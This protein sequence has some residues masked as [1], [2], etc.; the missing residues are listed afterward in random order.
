M[1]SDADL[2]AD[3]LDALERAGCQFF[4]CGGPTLEP[5]GMVTCYRCVEVARLRERL[6]LRIVH[7]EETPVYAQA[8]RLQREA[9]DAHRVL[10]MDEA[11]AQARREERALT[12]QGA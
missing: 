5:I 4:A 10:S 2:L 7:L 3:A 8:V 9:R 12:S 11:L 6:G 1:V